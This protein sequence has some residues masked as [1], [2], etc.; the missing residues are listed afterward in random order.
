MK[1][2]NRIII[3]ILI[4]IFILVLGYSTFTNYFEKYST[5]SQALDEKTDKMIWVNGTIKKDSLTSFITGE[6]LFILTDG[7]SDMNV[8]FRE[9]LPPSFGTESEVVLL[10]K[11]D[12]STFHA[13]K[14]I[15]KCP[16]KYKG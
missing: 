12:N 6:Y 13:T 2:D 7:I 10:G 1:I 8:S 3:G 14:M 4:I 9:E 15:T 16:T 11:L 5:V